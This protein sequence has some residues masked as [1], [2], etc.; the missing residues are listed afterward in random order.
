VG[1]LATKGPY[2][3]TFDASKKEIHCV[4]VG[5]ASGGSH[6]AFWSVFNARLKQRSAEMLTSKIGTIANNQIASSKLSELSENLCEDSQ[7][8]GGWLSFIRNEVN[9]SQR[10][11]T[12][13]PYEGYESSHHQRLHDSRFIWVEDPL[14]IDLK[15]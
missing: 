7:S 6:Q 11:G 14:K 1:K 2:C 4:K 10:W 15:T 8:G 9:Y 5:A 13:Y 12:W 3:C